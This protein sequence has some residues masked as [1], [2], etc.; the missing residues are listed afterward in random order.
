MKLYT[1]EQVK[2]LLAQQRKECVIEYELRGTES[3]AQG[4][5]LNAPEPQFPTPIKFEEW[6]P[7]TGSSVMEAKLTILNYKKDVISDYIKHIEQNTR[8][9]E[10]ENERWGKIIDSFSTQLECDHTIIN[11]ALNV[12]E[13]ILVRDR[14][15]DLNNFEH[16]EGIEDSFPKSQPLTL[17]RCGQPTTGFLFFDTIQC[18][19]RWYLPEWDQMYFDWNEVS[20]W[21]Y[22]KNS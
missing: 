17:S 1:E 21:K 11:D 13:W 20:F 7:L 9:K 16:V 19:M 5:I 10:S 18:K 22:Y 12:Q 2:E 15:P 8:D 14:I 4:H 3:K 6:S